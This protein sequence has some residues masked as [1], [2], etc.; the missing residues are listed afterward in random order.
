VIVPIAP[1]H[2]P[3]DHTESSP[4]SSACAETGTRATGESRRCINLEP[5]PLDLP[6]PNWEAE[7][8]DNTM[9]KQIQA[10]AQVERLSE[11][12][13]VKKTRRATGQDSQALVRTLES[14]TP[15]GTAHGRPP[16]PAGS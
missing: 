5:P 14:M 11:S 13:R 6:P 1:A 7:P 3:L 12:L 9:L 8:P 15:L 10:P 2:A 4:T 16:V